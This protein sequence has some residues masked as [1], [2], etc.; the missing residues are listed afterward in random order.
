MT[1]H[2]K[3]RPGIIRLSDGKV[4]FDGPAGMKGALIQAEEEAAVQ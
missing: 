4:V 1:F 3:H 2:C